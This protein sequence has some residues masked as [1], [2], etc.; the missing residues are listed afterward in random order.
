MSL[1]SCGHLSPEQSTLLVCVHEL[2]RQGDTERL[3]AGLAT[4]PAAA[5]TRTSEG[6]P[7][8]TAVCHSEARAVSLLL[9]AGADPNDGGEDEEC[10]LYWACTRPKTR[11]HIVKLLL[12]YGADPNTIFKDDGRPLLSVAMPLAAFRLL[13]QNGATPGLRDAKGNTP[14]HWVVLSI[15]SDVNRRVDLLCEHG[16]DVD[17]RNDAEETPLIRT[18]AATAEG[19]PAIVAHLLVK[20]ADPSASDS[21]GATALHRIAVSSSGFMDDEMA[22]ESAAKVADI[23]LANGASPNAVD[24][25]GNT[26][27]HSAALR[28]DLLLAEHLIARGGDSE[29]KNGDGITAKDIIERTRKAERERDRRLGW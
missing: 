12:E 21:S 24:R 25:D 5:V 14:L 11:H 28:G 15:Y 26:P 22:A 8:V 13:L 3:A 23:L 6:L 9:R 10:P 4:S 18:C 16:V 1:T 7:L 29:R 20:G 27:S 17:T 19:T 2:I